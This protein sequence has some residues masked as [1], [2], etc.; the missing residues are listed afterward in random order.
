M[1]RHHVLLHGTDPL[2]KLEISDKHRRL[3]IEQE[4][5]ETQIRLRRAV[6][7]SMGPGPLSGAVLRKAKQAR[8]PLHALFRLKKFDCPDELEPVLAKAGEVWKVET[9]PILNARED[10]V[11]AHDALVALLDLAIDDV[12]RMEVA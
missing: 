7:D 12:D 11:A 1:K 5:R 9:R 2:D 8:F 6:V 10:P 4:L 3:R